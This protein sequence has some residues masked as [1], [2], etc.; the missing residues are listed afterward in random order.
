MTREELYRQ[1]GEFLFKIATTRHEAGKAADV[2]LRA[3]GRSF[4][5]GL[6]V[7]LSD[8]VASVERDFEQFVL[9]KYGE[10][11]EPDNG[12]TRAQDAARREREETEQV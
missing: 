7:P 3:G 4:L 10:R 8:H 5:C 6:P 11:I 1:H 12:L 9:A 2:A